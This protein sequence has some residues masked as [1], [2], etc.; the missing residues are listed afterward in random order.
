MT[1]VIHQWGLIGLKPENQPMDEYGPLIATSH[2]WAKN[3]V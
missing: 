2:I 3:I 1:L